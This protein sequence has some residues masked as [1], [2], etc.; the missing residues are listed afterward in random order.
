ME[1]QVK[2]NFIKYINNKVNIKINLKIQFL[3]LVKRFKN[4][5]Y[6]STITLSLNG[7]NKNMMQ[8]NNDLNKQIVIG[9]LK[10]KTV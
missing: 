6:S 7:V 4:K 9:I 2:L 3:F 1:V 10:K 8:V 5:N